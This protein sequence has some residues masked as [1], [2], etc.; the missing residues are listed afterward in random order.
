M[1][2]SLLDN[3]NEFY[4][5]SMQILQNVSMKIV[6]LFNSENYLLEIEMFRPSYMDGLSKENGVWKVFN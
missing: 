6:A 5:D 2:T 1:P 4:F 3:S